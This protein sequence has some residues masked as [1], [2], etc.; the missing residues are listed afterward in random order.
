MNEQITRLGFSQWLADNS[1]PAIPKDFTIARV[2]SVNKNSYLI[3]TGTSDMYVELSGKFLFNSDSTLDLPT[4]GD[5]ITA[6][7]FDNDTF[8]IIHDILPRKT[9]IRRKAAGKK[10]DYQLIA[11]NID[12]AIIIQALDSNYNPRR[13]ER[14]LVMVH[15]SHITPVVFLSKKDLLTPQEVEARV[16]DIRS[17]LPDL[18]VIAFSNS[19]DSDIA[20]VRQYFQ[21]QKTYC[22]LGSSGVGKTTLLNN[23]LEQESYKTQPIREKD[24][25]GRHTTTRRELT[26][27]PG[28]AII[29]DTP[30]MREFGIMD[31]EQGLDETFSEIVILAEECRYDN[32][33]HT[34]ETGCA[35]KAAV[36]SGK[37][38]KERYE[39]YLKMVK[40]SA[41]YE[42]SYHER[43]QRERQFGK[44]M[45]NYHKHHK[46]GK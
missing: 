26:I 44:M 1:L 13:L 21:P 46:N 32:C 4:V 23:L 34:V 11:A 18:E 24:G 14:Y 7:I 10:I 36:E 30:G 39:N 16:H 28:E 40:E 25:R 35:V 19:T 5:W 29:I 31:A 45:H 9:I 8:G 17:M 27:L 41:F 6:Q 15:E 43:K 3:S 12:I 20:M 37:I 33:T 38:A 22:L 2:I 42:M